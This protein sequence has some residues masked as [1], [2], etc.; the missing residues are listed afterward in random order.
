MKSLK[1]EIIGNIFNKIGDVAEK[2]AS[3]TPEV[4]SPFYFGCEI[5]LEGIEEND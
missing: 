2:N 1:E 3:L 4:F 5:S